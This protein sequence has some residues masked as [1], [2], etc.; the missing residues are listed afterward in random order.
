MANPVSARY[1]SISKS[2]LLTEINS[3]VTLFPE[4]GTL[5]SNG[6]PFFSNDCV[7]D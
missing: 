7:M 3:R 5:F 4:W 6:G 1:L 2:K